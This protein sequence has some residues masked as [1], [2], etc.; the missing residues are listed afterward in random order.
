LQVLTADE[1]TYACPAGLGASILHL[2]TTVV[3][4]G[5]VPAAAAA[6][7]AG[8]VAAARDAALAVAGAA[9][10]AAAQLLSDEWGGGKEVWH[11]AFALPLSGPPPPP[12]PLAG[13]YAL[14]P[15][16]ALP[17]R[18]A[19]GWPPEVEGRVRGGLALPRLPYSLDPHPQLAAARRAF[20]ALFPGDEPAAFLAPDAAAQ[21]AQAEARGEATGDLEEL[22]LA[23]ALA[24]DA[25]AEALRS[26]NAA[27][28][29]RA[30]G[31][32]VEALEAALLGRAGGQGGEKTARSGGRNPGALEARL[33]VAEVRMAELLVK[34][35]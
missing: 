15:P 26:A 20:A 30:L 22:Q 17:S 19:V 14:L 35:E 16:H 31:A 4:A 11:L 2:T 25:H 32:R 5:A 23:A 1:T 28:A 6:A 3:V 9:L 10:A 18:A 34:L 12:L 24:A 33:A 8:G 29:L 13:P 21:L 27:A 7:A